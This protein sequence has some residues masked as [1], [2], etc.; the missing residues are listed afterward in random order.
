MHKF[1]DYI[2]GETDDTLLIDR[3]EDNTLASLMMVKQADRTIDIISREMDPV[4]YNTPEFAE[5]IKQMVLKNKKSKVRILAHEPTLIVRRGHRLV[6]L[7][8]QLTSFIEIR[9]PSFEHANYS[10][11][12]FI[13]DTTGYIHRLNPER[14]EGKL[15]FNDKRISRILTHQFDEI[16][17]KSRSDPNFK[18]TLL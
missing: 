6:D 16:W 14:Y 4:I 11:S 12:L 3:S 10:D 5:T 8:M 13:A 18:R 9:V 2:L 15:N 7:A 17:D 1:E